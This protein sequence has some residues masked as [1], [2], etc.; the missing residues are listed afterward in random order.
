MAK[1]VR[2]IEIEAGDLISFG[3][4]CG[5]SLMTGTVTKVTADFAF[6]KSTWSYKIGKKTK[7]VTSSHRRWHERVAVI[8]KHNKS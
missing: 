3:D 5:S 8:Q 7:V 1:D 2:G 6:M 4:S